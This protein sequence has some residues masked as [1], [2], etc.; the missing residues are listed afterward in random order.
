MARIGIVG[1]G[2]MGMIHYLA[3]KNVAGAK[4]SA[5]VTRDP[6]KRAGD[7]TSIQGNFGPRGQHEDL[8][9]V[10]AFSTMEEM[11]ASDHVDLV[12]V[13]LPND[14][15]RVAVE[16]ALA[17]GKHVLVEKAIALTVVD[18]DAML[19]AAERARRKL[20][21][22]HVLPFFAD[23]RFAL[24]AVQSRRF[25]APRAAHLRR[26]I[27]PPQWS[28]DIA[29][30]E[31]SGGP[32]IDLHIHDTH[33]IVLAFGV[34]KAIA[35]QGVMAGDS[36]EYVASSY[37]YENGPV[38]TATSG[39]LAAGSRPFT[40]G[41]EIYFE[42]AT[43]HYEAGGPLSLYTSHGLQHPALGESDPV[44]SFRDELEYAVRAVSD[45]GPDTLL[46]AQLAR[47]ALA[48]CRAEEAS[49]RSGREVLVR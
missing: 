44:D 47:D 5:I 16:Q 8:A 22:A 37:R 23:F 29:D 28:A 11:L 17:A 43:L 31:R 20:L 21:V 7:W 26:H 42:E 19:A 10:E 12:D 34:P 18:A 48:L 46:S 32:I 2:F 27:S 41:Y 30:R 49:V 15:H 38:V 4:V 3:Y 13:C 25:G 36:I 45:D 6:K 1:I 33:W 9:G 39:A 24:E 35:S 40:H 14:L